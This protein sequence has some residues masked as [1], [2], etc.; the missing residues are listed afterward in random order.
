[1]VTG[2]STANAAVILVDARKG[3]LTQTKRH[4][5]LVSL[6]GIRHVALAVNKMDLVDFSS[7]VFREIVKEYQEFAST[8]GFE[9]IISIPVSALE[10]DNVIELSERTPWYSGKSLLEYLETVDVGMEESEKAFRMPVHWVNRAS[11]DFRGFSGTIKSGK[12]RPGVEVVIPS[13]GQIAAVERIVTMDGDIEE[14]VAGQAVT[15]TLDKE[16][17]ISRGDLMSDPSD[18]PTHA[19]QFRAKLVWL[20]EQPLLPR[21][22]YLIKLNAN[23]T[24]AQVTDLKEKIDVNTL[25][26]LP[27]KILEMNEVGIV[28]LSVARPISFDSFEAYGSTGCFIL[29]DRETF[30]TVGSGMIE[31]PLR[32]STNIHRQE[33]EIDKNARALLLDQEPRCLWFTGLSGSGKS[34]I[35]NAVAKELHAMGKIAYVLD[36]DNVRHGLNR[37]LGFTDADRV[38][39]I[40]RVAETAKLMVDAGLIVICSFISP[41]RAERKMARELF[42]DGDFFEIFVATP[43]EVCE[44]RDPKGLYAKARKGELK[45]FTGVDSPYEIPEREREREQT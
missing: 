44:A 19:D 24:P 38:E 43:L 40:R 3:L 27:G 10:G 5:Y 17:D 4:S 7:Q 11:Y 15:L 29:I 6:V 22:T 9:E 18:R 21:R 31:Y 25:A 36:G 45:N 28:N 26:K 20:H 33:F 37:D 39:N 41:F 32:R 34:T 12:I 2:A 30:A 14:A 23:I 13:S 35:A 42:D 16:I 8:L 1:M